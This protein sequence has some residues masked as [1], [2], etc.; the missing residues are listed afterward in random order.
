MSQNSNID[1]AMQL[2]YK[3]LSSEIHGYWVRDS[4]L[5]L[6]KDSSEED[7]CLLRALYIFGKR[8]GVE[9][10]GIKIRQEGFKATLADWDERTNERSE[11]FE[12]EERLSIRG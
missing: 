6:P 8:Q 4:E 12:Q 5:N 7:N 1:R 3:K 11:V 10:D 9:L 2:L